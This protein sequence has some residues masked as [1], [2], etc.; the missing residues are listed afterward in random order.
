M[1]MSGYNAGDWPPSEKTDNN[2]SNAEVE[3]SGQTETKEIEP[4]PNSQIH[5]VSGRARVRIVQQTDPSTINSSKDNLHSRQATALSV[6][7][8]QHEPSAVETCRPIGEL[9]KHNCWSRVS[10]MKESGSLMIKPDWHPETMTVPEGK[11]NA[12][13]F[14]PTG[15]LIS[16]LLS[17]VSDT[18]RQHYCDTKNNGATSKDPVEETEPIMR[19]PSSFSPVRWNRDDDV[20][21]TPHP[22]RDGASSTVLVVRGGAS[23]SHSSNNNY[24]A[25]PSGPAI[26]SLADADKEDRQ[27]FT[28]GL[29]KFGGIQSIH[30]ENRI[31][32]EH[33]ISSDTEHYQN[34]EYIMVTEKSYS[35]DLFAQNTK[36][37]DLVD[38]H[39]QS[40]SEVC[41]CLSR[42]CSTMLDFGRSSSRRLYDSLYEED[43]SLYGSLATIT[44]RIGLD[45]SPP[46]PDTPWTKH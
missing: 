35:E 9:P 45:A 33:G 28:H 46:R 26:P 23:D 31:Q 18:G 16:P 6:V 19:K 1:N 3:T 13:I 10:E 5:S 41:M 20:S 11:E 12:D 15:P 27:R 42:Y 30:K 21:V 14:G 7:R 44:K 17:Q 2:Y 37:S 38:F 4:T 25:A 24:N 34:D 29:G 36:Q 43:P 40:T 39:R 32:P 8:P 22:W